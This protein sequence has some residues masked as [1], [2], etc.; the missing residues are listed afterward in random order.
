ML[1]TGHRGG[2]RS[3][4]WFIPLVFGCHGGWSSFRSDVGHR[5]CDDSGHRRRGGSG[6]VGGGVDI[7]TNTFTKLLKRIAFT[8]LKNEIHYNYKMIQSAHH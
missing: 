2:R 1:T 3:R 8:F 4:C 7:K 5:D 6:L